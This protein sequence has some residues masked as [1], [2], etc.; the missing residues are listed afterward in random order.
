MIISC[1]PSTDQTVHIQDDKPAGGATFDKKEKRGL[2]KMQ[3]GVGR[4]A[5][6]KERAEEQKGRGA[7]KARSAYIFKR[8]NCF[9]RA[10]RR[11]RNHGEEL[12]TRPDTSASNFGASTEQNLPNTQKIFLKRSWLTLT[13]F[14]S[15]IPLKMKL[16]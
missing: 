16:F 4:N 8:A 13:H 14:K 5:R 15:S 9:P 1:V 7:L 2:G 10:E 6:W 3:K 11:S 12:Q